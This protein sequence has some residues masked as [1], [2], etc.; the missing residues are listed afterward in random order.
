MCPAQVADAMQHFL[1]DG[2]GN[3]F[4]IT[5]PFYAPD[6]YEELVDLLVPE[7]SRNAGCIGTT[8]RARPC[9]SM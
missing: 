4:Q 3:G 6:Y 8:T 7:L 9:A 2:G 1:E 5:P